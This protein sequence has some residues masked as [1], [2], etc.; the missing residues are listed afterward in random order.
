MITPS[1]ISGLPYTQLVIERCHA[2]HILTSHGVVI[3]EE[4]SY[5]L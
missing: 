2:G 5:G 1:P 3:E 4:E